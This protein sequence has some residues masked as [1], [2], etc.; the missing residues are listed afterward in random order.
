MDLER[1]H[2]FPLGRWKEVTIFVRRFD[3]FRSR[4]LNFEVVELAKKRNNAFSDLCTAIIKWYPS[5]DL[6]ARGY[7][8]GGSVYERMISTS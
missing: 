1:Q 4:R 2:H 5:R 6:D 8:C 3:P 7:G